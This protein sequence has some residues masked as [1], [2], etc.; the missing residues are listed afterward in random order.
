MNGRTDRSV[1]NSAV[2]RPALKIIKIHEFYDFFNIR[3][4]SQKIRLQENYL[5]SND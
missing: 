4:S 1:S 5:S 3:E 2:Y